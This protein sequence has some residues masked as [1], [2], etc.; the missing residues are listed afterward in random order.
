MSVRF[1]RLGMLAVIGLASA[2]ALAAPATRPSAGPKLV[3]PWAQMT[4]LTPAQKGKIAVMHKETLKKIRDLKE[5]ENAAILAMFDDKQRTEYEQVAAQP[6]G[7]TKASS[8]D[9]TD[10]TPAK[11]GKG[12]SK[13]K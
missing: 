6:K 8:D 4:T 7:K 2:A 3:K 9:G 1:N 12:M 10:P 11:P 5:A 13:L